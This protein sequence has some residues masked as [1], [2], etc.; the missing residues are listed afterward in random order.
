GRTGQ[1]A[2][3]RGN[4]QGVYAL[5]PQEGQRLQNILDF[6]AA[7]QQRRIGQPQYFGRQDR[8]GTQQAY[9]P[10]QRLRDVGNQVEQLYRDRTERRHFFPQAG[11]PD[12]E[13]Y[14]RSSHAAA[15]VDIT[16]ILCA[17]MPVMSAMSSPGC[18]GLAMYPSMPESR[19][20]PR[21]PAM[22][23]AV[24]ATMGMCLP[25]WPSR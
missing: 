17:V 8:I 5:H 23:C 14:G 18:M 11:P 12:R 1:A 24:M 9:Y 2:H 25:V 10:G 7:P 6:G 16:A 20:R 21:S 3:G 15:C 4:D 22:A 13:G 19:Q